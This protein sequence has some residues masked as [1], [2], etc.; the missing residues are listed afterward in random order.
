M[1]LIDLLDDKNVWEQYYKYKCSLLKASNFTEELRDYIDDEKYKTVVDAIRKKETFP[2]PKKAVISKMSTQKKRTVYS[3]PNNEN[4]VF[5]LMTNLILRRYDKIFS[6]GLYSFR[7]N[8][9]ATSAVKYLKS[10]P[11][12]DNLYSYKVDVSNYFNSISIDKMTPILQ[13]T[14]END[15]ELFHFLSALLS[16]SCVMDK[17]KII[18][19]NK[20]IMAGTPQACFYANLYL[21]DMDRY[22]EERNILYIRYS[23]D[24]IVF[25]DTREKVK[26][27]AEIIKMF[28]KERGL[29]VNS[30]KEHFSTPEEGWTFLGFSYCK[31]K[32]DI[33]P[34]SVKKIK[35]KMRRKSRALKRWYER[36][37]KCCEQAARAFIR[38]FN[39][40][41]FGSVS[42][43]S[44]DNDLTW[45]YWYFPVINTTESL[46]VIDS[47]AQDC[48]RYLMS[49]KRNKG[50]FKVHYSDI[51]T[52]GLR[53]LVH[54]YYAK[55]VTKVP[56]ND[57]QVPG[58]V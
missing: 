49:G 27:Y 42:N 25:A 19:E 36:E 33:A 41:L 7:P 21:M 3:Y 30:A 11:D 32:V 34:S 47:Y 44:D 40:K 56:K 52:L 54:E 4:I 28:L 43:E 26:E 18:K 31:G 38:I 57:P 45:S 10:H 37:G 48:V 17:G 53:N 8:K 1:S 51:K 14:L 16:E 12:I 23:D 50:R 58:G 29:S 9:N 22:F 24:I 20:G 55:N 13:N 2:L 5:K 46:N 35:A 15:T 39:R 6:R